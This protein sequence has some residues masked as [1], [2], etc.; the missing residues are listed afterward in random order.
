MRLGLF[1]VLMSIA[2]ATTDHAV[3]RGKRETHG[4]P[5]AED[6]FMGE[7]FKEY[8]VSVHKNRSGLITARTRVE[9]YCA[10]GFPDCDPNKQPESRVSDVLCKIPGGY[11]ESVMP[12]GGHRVSEPRSATRHQ[13]GQGALDFGLARPRLGTV[14]WPRAGLAGAGLVLTAGLCAAQE[15]K[16]ADS[17]LEGDGFELPVREHRAVAP[18]RGFAREEPQSSRNGWV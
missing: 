14:K 9:F 18:S 5:A 12:A 3:A 10:P 2:Y 16:F 8:L 17:L 15:L 6:C 11:I 1:I 7:C 4:P 13:I